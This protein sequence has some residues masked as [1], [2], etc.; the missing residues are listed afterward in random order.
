MPEQIP[1]EYRERERNKGTRSGRGDGILDQVGLTG[2][3]ELIALA[4]NGIGLVGR[5]VIQSCI[6]RAEGGRFGD[7]YRGGND[8]GY[9][10]VDEWDQG[11]HGVCR[12][13]CKAASL[14]KGRARESEGAGFQY[15]GGSL[16]CWR[17]PLWSGRSRLVR[18]RRGG[19]Q[20]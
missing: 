10:V 5:S 7:G 3:A 15:P 13:S 18:L 1:Y 2:G 17:A 16:V 4:D 19:D 12:L 20:G 8:H 9:Q 14:S 6:G 11:G